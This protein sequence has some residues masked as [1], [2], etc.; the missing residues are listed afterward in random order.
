M[1]KK[2]LELMKNPS[3]ENLRKAALILARKKEIQQAVKMRNAASG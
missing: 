2:I 1:D 3:N